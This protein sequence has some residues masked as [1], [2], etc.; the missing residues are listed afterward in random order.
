MD[1]G[2]PLIILLNT[3]TAVIGAVQYRDY[4]QKRKFRVRTTYDRRNRDCVPVN[5]VI[6][7]TAHDVMSKEAHG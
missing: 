4:H 2:L 7:Q 5:P 6:L 3:C 1:F